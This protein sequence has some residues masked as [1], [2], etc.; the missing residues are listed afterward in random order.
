MFSFECPECGTRHKE[1]A[2]PI[3]KAKLVVKRAIG[4]PGAELENIIPK[5]FATGGCGCASYARRMDKWGVEGCEERFDKIVSYLHLQAGKKRILSILGPINRMVARYWVTTAIN[6]ARATLEA[7]PVNDNGDWFVAVTTAP[8]RDCTLLECIYSLRVAGWEPTLF[9]E[10]GATDTDASTIQNDEK[11]GVWHNWL[12]S[13]RYAVYNTDASVIM[14]VQDD[15]GFHPDSRDFAESALWPSE[16]CGFLSLYTPRHYSTLK[17]GKVNP[18]GINRIQTRSLWGACA[19]VWPREALKEVV[20]SK[21]AKHWRGAGPK[22]KKKESRTDFRTRRDA[23]F[24]GKEKDPTTIAN[25]DTAIGKAV[26]RSKR[27]MYFV[28]PSP[29]RHIA[30]HSTLGHG[31]NGGNRNCGRCADHS[32]PLADQVNPLTSP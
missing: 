17:S 25:S 18:L 30:T 26:N 19:L 15:C 9:A 24:A 5:M 8:R 20:N 10:P 23:W 6:R 31:G 3:C 7:N 29:V 12:A 13:A 14:T 2:C 32:I 27:T 21:T 4:R 16:N 11:L 22:P 28:D 1:K